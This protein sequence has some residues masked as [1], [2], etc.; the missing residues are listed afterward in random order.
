MSIA[1]KP[2]G[3]RERLVVAAFD[4]M[5]R[6][7][8]HGFGL[9][10]VLALAEAPKGVLYHH[11]PGGK[12]E[13]AIA[14]IESAVD[15]IVAGLE[16]LRASVGDP[17]Q[18]L[19]LWLSRAQDRLKASQFEQG[20]PLAAV[21]LESTSEDRSLRGALEQGFAT[22]RTVLADML[23]ETGLPRERAARF[24]ALIVSAYEGALLQARVAGS[25][26]TADATMKLL[27]QLLQSEIDSV[28]T[29]Q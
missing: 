15:Q 18:C 14:V 1:S 12:T 8:L 27:L 25:N 7:G 28:R 24:S 23:A 22:I 9:N 4:L 13:L 11:F 19:R 29:S 17:L 20:C 3:T 26:A 10:E 16:Q 6:K 2:A 5:R 21:A